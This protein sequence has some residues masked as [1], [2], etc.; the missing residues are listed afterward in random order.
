MKTLLIALFMMTAFIGFFYGVVFFNEATGIICG[1]LL[2]A[3]II[4]DKA[5]G[6][7]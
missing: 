4:R 2:L 7:I 6:T 5:R 3:L 1:L